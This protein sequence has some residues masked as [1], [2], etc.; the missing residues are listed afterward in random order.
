[1][2][3]RLLL[4]VA[5]TLFACA[6]T[7]AAQP[8]KILDDVPSTI[9]VNA[10]YLFHMHGLVVEL[11]GP[12]ARSQ[13]GEYRYRWTIETL[14]DRGFVVISEV[15]PQRT[16]ILRYANM[17]AGQVA[18][19]RAAGVPGD[20][21][22]VTGISKGAEITVLTT[23]AVND[24]RVRFVVMAGCGTRD[25]FNVTGA[26]TTFGR[27]PQGRVLAIRDRVDTEAGPC[28][29]YFPAAPGLDFSE[30][31]L[32]VNRGHGLFYTPERV[33]IDPVVEFASK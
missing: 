28:A 15:R 11:Q 1:M 21:I 32:D 18:K 17:V 24:P 22:I 5:L 13:W 20:N 19:L 10:R 30:I 8:R 27:P 31:V 23:A 16:P 4:I 9:E 3:H 2:P 25:V 14:A 7:A 33:W 12:N 29:R 26:L 6:P